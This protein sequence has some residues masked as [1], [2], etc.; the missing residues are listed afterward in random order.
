MT[1]LEGLLAFACSQKLG[2]EIGDLLPLEDGL[3]DTEDG[4][5]SL[6]ARDWEICS[7]G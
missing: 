7:Y 2:L 6:E 1:L 3:G 4:D 5:A